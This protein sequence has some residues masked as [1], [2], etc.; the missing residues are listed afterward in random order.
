MEACWPTPSIL[1]T[2]PRKLLLPVRSIDAFEPSARQCWKW[3]LVVA[4]P[5]PVDQ[6]RLLDPDASGSAA[7]LELDVRVLIQ[8]LQNDRVLDLA[9]EKLAW[10]S[11]ILREHQLEWSVSATMEEAIVARDDPSAKLDPYP[12]Q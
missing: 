9:T 10:R 12:V 2:L 8:R 5:R 11:R 6:E 7:L 1:S 4:R 3:A